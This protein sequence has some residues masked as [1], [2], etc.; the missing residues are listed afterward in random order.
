MSTTSPTGQKPP[1]SWLVES[2][3]VTL[4]CC[5]PFGIAGIVNAS[6]VESR[7]YAG[8]IDGSN[9]SSEEAAKWTKI[10]FWVGIAGIVIY[11]RLGI[12]TRWRNWCGCTQQQLKFFF[13]SSLELR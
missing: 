10:G 2:I 3:L 5:L 4:F 7:F 6:K 13:G 1:K 9:R 11:N 8:D 12:N